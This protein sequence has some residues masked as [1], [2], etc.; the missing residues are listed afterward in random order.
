MENNILNIKED[1]TEGQVKA[2][3]VV[4][5]GVYYGC[6]WGLI[7][8]G[9]SGISNFLDDIE[10]GLYKL[11]DGYL[12]DLERKFVFDFVKENIENLPKKALELFNN[13]YKK[14]IDR[15]V[16]ELKKGKNGYLGIY[17]INSNPI[18]FFEGKGIF[19]HNIDLEDFLTICEKLGYMVDFNGRLLAPN[20]VKTKEKK[21]LFLQLCSLSA[22]GDAVVVKVAKVG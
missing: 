15:L 9:T 13:N 6:S 3:S 18:T 11:K 16:S 8:K 12:I 22:N 19:S 14:A 20:V 1:I 17:S 21:K 10:S 4:L 7:S 2:L 5:P